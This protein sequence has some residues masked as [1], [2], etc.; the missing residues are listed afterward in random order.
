[1]SSHRGFAEPFCG[2]YVTTASKASSGDTFKPVLINL[3]TMW[4][5]SNDG[6]RLASRYGLKGVWFA[7]ATELTVC[8]MVIPD[9]PYT[10][11]G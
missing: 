10:E 3:F 7:M 8:E 4:H 9:T 2:K 11:N 6:I 5:T 1:M